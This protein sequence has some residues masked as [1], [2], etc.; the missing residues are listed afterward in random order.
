MCPNCGA[1]GFAKYCAQCGEKRL[2]RE[3]WKLSSAV[4]AVVSEITD[5]ERSKLWRTLRKLILRPG[6][7]TAEYWR[8][9]R[10]PYVGPIKLYLFFFALNLILYSAYRPT[11]VV[12][13][14][15]MVAVDRSGAFEE[16]ISRTAEN[17]GVPRA[18]VVAEINSRWQSYVSLT[19]LLGPAFLALALRALLFRSGRFYAEHLIFGLH[20]SAFAILLNILTWCFYLVVGIAFTPAFFVL[21]GL[22]AIAGLVYFVLAV[23]RVYETGKL[24]SIIVGGLSYL[25]YVAMIVI[26][27]GMALRLAL[28][29]VGGE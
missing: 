10:Q 24:G 14:E 19:Q 25:F 9:R 2:E 29:R 23:G 18:V 22:Q 28:T 26:I 5:L 20:A 13:I 7:L 6:E 27:Q 3:E 17:R 4:G 1:A 21:G 15:A 12:D 11:A 8:G 16:I